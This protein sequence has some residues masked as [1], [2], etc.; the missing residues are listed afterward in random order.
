[1]A[2]GLVTRCGIDDKTDPSLDQ[3]L[4]MTRSFFSVFFF[5]T[6]SDNHLLL[7]LLPPLTPCCGSLLSKPSVSPRGCALWTRLY[8][9]VVLGRTHKDQ[10]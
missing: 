3:T 9:G 4:L 5:T 1:M 10:T 8:E 7:L 2:S 6:T